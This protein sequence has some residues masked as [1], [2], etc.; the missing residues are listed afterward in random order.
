MHPVKMIALTLLCAG[1]K[2]FSRTALRG[3]QGDSDVV[4][5]RACNGRSVYQKGEEDGNVLFQPHSHHFWMVGPSNQTT[6]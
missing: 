2:G 4:P 1:G 6:I 5:S 3:G